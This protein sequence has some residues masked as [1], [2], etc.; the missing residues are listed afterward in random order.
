MNSGYNSSK[1]PTLTYQADEEPEEGTPADKELKK[2]RGQQ[3]FIEA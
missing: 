3:P 1:G 2:G